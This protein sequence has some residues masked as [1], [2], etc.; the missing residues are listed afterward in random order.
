MITP[1][2]AHLSAAF[3]CIVCSCPR[4]GRRSVSLSSGW[5]R[6]DKSLSL[7]IRS[8]FKKFRSSE[9]KF[10]IFFTRERCLRR[11]H[12]PLVMSLSWLWLL[13]PSVHLD[14]SASAT[15]GVDLL[16]F[17][18]VDTECKEAWVTVLADDAFLP[19]VLVLLHSIRQVNI[20]PS[21]T[22]QKRRWPT[23]PLEILKL[24]KSLLS[25]MFHDLGS[26]SSQL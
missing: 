21:V 5:K 1:G 7:S 18:P 4:E 26:L 19:G 9:S 6:E 11:P 17:Y 3:P 12:W 24:A 20:K 23:E 10:L 25:S 15:A 8:S 14:R 2:K 22:I 13:N 16:S